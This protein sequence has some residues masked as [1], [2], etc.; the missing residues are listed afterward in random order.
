M[1]VD[2]GHSSRLQHPDMYVKRGARE[3]FDR[4]QLVIQS[5]EVGGLTCCPRHDVIVD[6]LD[7]LSILDIKHD[8]MI[9]GEARCVT[10]KRHWY[11]TMRPYIG[12]SGV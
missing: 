2:R 10:E 8:R 11:A 3:L 6:I 1:E 5:L 4:D 9:D 12:R 7:E